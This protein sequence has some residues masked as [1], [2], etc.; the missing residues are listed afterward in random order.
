MAENDPEINNIS[1]WK[2]LNLLGFALMK[3]RLAIGEKQGGFLMLFKLEILKCID[4]NEDHILAPIT[5]VGKWTLVET[6]DDLW[7]SR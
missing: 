2:G 7:R 1:K 6:M 4:T 5:K 3:A